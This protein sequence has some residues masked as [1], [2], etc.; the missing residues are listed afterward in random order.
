MSEPA[1]TD[2]DPRLLEIL[3]C[4]VTHG[5]L[6]YDRDKAE[7]I[8]LTQALGALQPAP[9]AGDLLSN[10]E[11]FTVFQSYYDTAFSSASFHH[12][13]WA[14][15]VLLGGLIQMLLTPLPSAKVYHTVSTGFA[16]LLAA[17]ATYETG[18]PAFITEHGIYMLERHIEIMMAEW[19]GDQIDTG[20]SLARAGHDLRDLWLAVFQTYTRACYDACNPIV[21]L[22]TANNP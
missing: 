10:E 9:T 2:V 11:M 17:R 16:G 5:T 4:P 1:E 6:E 15:R 20:L 19:I 8:S 3:V 13:F 22:Y 21:A 7:L 14:M 12:F 18:R